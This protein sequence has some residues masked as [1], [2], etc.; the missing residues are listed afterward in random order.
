MGWPTLKSGLKTGER[1]GSC[2]GGEA[3]TP[4]GKHEAH[5]GRRFEVPSLYLQR[6]GA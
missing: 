4:R 2:A 1:V 5:T 6:L 3:I